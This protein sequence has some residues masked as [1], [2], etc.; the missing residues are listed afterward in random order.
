MNRQAMF[1]ALFGIVCSLTLWLSRG[2]DANASGSSK[3]LPYYDS[4]D[5]TPWWTTTNHTVAPFSLTTQTG[6]SFTSNDLVGRVHIASF[7]YT[8]C[9]LVCPTLVSSVRK[10]SARIASPDL[11][12]LS[13][14]VTPDIDTPSVLEAFGR[15]RGIDSR[16]WK[17]LTGSRDTIYSL[18]RNSYFASDERLASQAGRDSFLHTEQLVLVDQRGQLRGVYN[19]SQPR[20]LDLLVEDARALLR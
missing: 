19:G 10:V 18:A 8:R 4:R 17:L 16:Q 20:D 13:F 6:E 12:V 3:A 7:I 11:V 1:V 5:L 14:S 15:E 9:A 2:I